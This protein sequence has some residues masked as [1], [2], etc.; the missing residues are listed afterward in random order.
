M[1]LRA[2]DVPTHPHPDEDELNELNELNESDEDELDELY[3]PPSPLDSPPNLFE[4]INLPFSVSPTYAYFP[5][6][7]DPFS[8]VTDSNISSND[9]NDSNDSGKNVSPCLSPDQ[10]A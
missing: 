5:P 8:S 7:S 6:D 2:N 4:P 9:S 10:D 3:L 1:S